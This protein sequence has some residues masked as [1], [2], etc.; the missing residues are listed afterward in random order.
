MG[1]SYK[2]IGK[3]EKTPFFLVEEQRVLDSVLS[4]KKSL[5]HYWSNNVVSY[6]VKT[7]SFPCVLRT[8]SNTGVWAEVVSEEEYD[9]AVSCGFNGQNC[10][11]NGPAKTQRFIKNAIE[12][13]AVLHLDGLSEIRT[14]LS[15]VGDRSVEFGVR[16]NATEPDF[17]VDALSG[18]ETSRFGIS[19]RDGDFDA[20]CKLITEKKNVKLTS[21]HLHCNTRYRSKE[22]YAWLAAFFVR[23]VKRYGLDTV[24]TFDIG[25]SFGHDFDCKEGQKGR[26][27]SWDEY[28]GAITTVLS[29]AGYS[30][31]NLRLIIEPGSS[32]ISNGADYYATIVG[33]RVYDGVVMMQMDG[34]RIH[35]DPHFARG[36]FSDAVTVV[37]SCVECD[38]E[39]TTMLCGSTCLEKDRVFLGKGGLRC[40]VGDRI[41]ISKTGAYT[42]GLSPFFFIQS[43]P[44]IWL[45]RVNGAIECVHCSKTLSKL[46][47]YIESES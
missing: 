46:K 30:P 5:D 13:G 45:R 29:N 25:G 10:V 33:K 42:L 34:S 20:L 14:F 41:R 11:C 32:L 24:N 26:W 36:S 3:I 28:F 35:V 38:A 23:V 39:T 15:E 18:N 2:D 16:V 21:L 1:C 17:P 27:P 8:L 22:G 37:G 6:S 43:V 7:N 47:D 9:L 40:S 31:E 12:A 19:V 4:I 44:D